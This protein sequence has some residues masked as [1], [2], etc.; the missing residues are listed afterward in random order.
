MQTDGDGIFR[1]SLENK[2][3]LPVTTIIYFLVTNG[4]NVKMYSLGL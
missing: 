3:Q 4:T 2:V 1:K